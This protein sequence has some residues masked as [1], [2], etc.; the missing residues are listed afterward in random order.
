M[1][2]KVNRH[3]NAKI[4]LSYK[5]KK[6]IRI[7]LIVLAAIA[8]VGVVTLMILQMTGTINSLGEL[9]QDMKAWFER[10]FDPITTVV[11]EVSEVASEIA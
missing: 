6:A 5:T 2:Y 4:R 9:G 10:L 11:E 8:L 1:A 3:G 7:T